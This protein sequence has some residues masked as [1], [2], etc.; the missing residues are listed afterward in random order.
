MVQNW[1][2]VGQAPNAVNQTGLLYGTTEGKQR[3]VEQ[4]N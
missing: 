1:L 4:N 3:E 2:D